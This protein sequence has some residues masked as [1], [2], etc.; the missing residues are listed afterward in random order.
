MFQPWVGIYLLSH[1]ISTPTMIPPYPQALLPGS[2]QWPEVFL[3]R[4]SPVL[5]RP[6]PAAPHDVSS[7]MKAPPAPTE[8]LWP[9]SVTPTTVA[10][11]EAVPPPSC[12]WA[13][14]QQQGNNMQVTYENIYIT[15][16]G[17]H[18]IGIFPYIWL[19]CMGNVGKYSKVPW[20]IWVIMHQLE[21]RETMGNW[22]F[23]LS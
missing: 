4:G 11:P 17:L 15:P 18:G 1:L 19:T 16:L 22:R 23:L 14:R 7:R 12:H 6:N 8:E 2:P 3:Q 5:H 9:F 10:N 21:S 13:F 20:R